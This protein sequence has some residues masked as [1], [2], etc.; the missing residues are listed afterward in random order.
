MVGLHTQCN[1]NS[2]AYSLVSIPFASI[3]PILLFHYYPTE[4]FSSTTFDS[5]KDTYPFNLALV[6]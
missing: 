2:D 5:I 3:R 6:T 1:S 4:S